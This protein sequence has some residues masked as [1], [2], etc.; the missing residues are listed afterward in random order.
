MSITANIFVLFDAPPSRDRLAQLEEIISNRTGGPVGSVVENFERLCMVEDA[1]EVV[2]VLPDG[3]LHYLAHGR[4][5]WDPHC[6]VS[7]NSPI[8]DRL[9]EIVYLSRWWSDNCP[10]G[11][12][13]EYALTML[14]LE[15]QPDVQRVWYTDSSYYHGIR[16]SAMSHERIH[17]LIDRYV[18]IG[19]ISEGKPARYTRNS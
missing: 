19:K 17:E 6:P 11:P 18:A 1:D 2:D 5:A 14:C 12:L 16:L 15:S 8:Q 3:T 10:E 4:N 9:F 7:G 13:M